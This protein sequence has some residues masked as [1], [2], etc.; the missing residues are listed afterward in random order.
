MFIGIY[1]QEIASNMKEEKNREWNSKK[2][3]KLKNYVE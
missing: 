1:T 3:N 2:K